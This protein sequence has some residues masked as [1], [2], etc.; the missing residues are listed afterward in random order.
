MV[1]PSFEPWHFEPFEAI[2]SLQDLANFMAPHG[3]APPV[4]STFIKQRQSL[5]NSRSTSSQSQCGHI[6]SSKSHSGSLGNGSSSGRYRDP[7]LSSAGISFIATPTTSTLPMTRSDQQQQQQHRQ[8]HQVAFALALA[9]TEQ[10]YSQQ[11]IGHEQRFFILTRSIN[12]SALSPIFVKI[13]D[14]LLL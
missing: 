2:S 7:N 14:Q 1:A 13:G 5:T 4:L 11:V 12:A 8:Q 6:P 10:S 3:Q 9:N